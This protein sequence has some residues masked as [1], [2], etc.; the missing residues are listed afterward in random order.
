MHAPSSIQ[1]TATSA[2]P[3]RRTELVAVVSPS[4]TCDATRPASSTNATATISTP[5]SLF[6][7]LVKSGLVGQVW[8]VFRSRDANP[9]RLYMALVERGRILEEVNTKLHAMGRDAVSD[10]QL[11][12]LLNERTITPTELQR[13]I[14]G[15]KGARKEQRRRATSRA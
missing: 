9:P 14:S 10:A 12:A 8:P 7:L 15:A 4:R 2:V 6:Q 1:V 5:A 3:V 13:L 11:A